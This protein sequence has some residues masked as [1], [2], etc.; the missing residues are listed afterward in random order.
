MYLTVHQ[1]YKLINLENFIFIDSV[2]FFSC[3]SCCR[4]RCCSSSVECIF[5]FIRFFISANDFIRLHNIFTT[6]QRSF[7]LGHRSRLYLDICLTFSLSWRKK[8]RFDPVL[9]SHRPSVYLKWKLKNEDVPLHSKRLIRNV[10]E[11]ITGVWSWLA[12]EF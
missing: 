11:L 4:G 6:K 9:L 3:S 8:I 12:I 10:N 1:L 7:A 2:G 5:S